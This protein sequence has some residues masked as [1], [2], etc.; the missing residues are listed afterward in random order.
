M[1]KPENLADE[2]EETLLRKI[3][4][5][6]IDCVLLHNSIERSLRSSGI[7]K[8]YTTNAK[9]KAQPFAKRFRKSTSSFRESLA[10]S[11]NFASRTNNYCSCE[12]IISRA[13]S[14][15]KYFSGKSWSASGESFRR[16]PFRL[17]RPKSEPVLREDSRQKRLDRYSRVTIPMPF[18][19]SIRKKSSKST[20][21]QK[22]LEKMLE[23]KRVREE[24][25][26]RKCLNPFKANPIPNSTYV[27]DSSFYVG[28]KITCN[29]FRISLR[30]F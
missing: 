27:L 8:R 18:Q 11:S 30:N 4:A 22:F 6:R 15:R 26:R 23:E 29:A 20:F 3:R 7:C 5:L 14:D 19:F 9:Q 2:E 1:E 16:V 17:Q 13:G 28:V 12:R 25:Q 21:S 24:E 10:A